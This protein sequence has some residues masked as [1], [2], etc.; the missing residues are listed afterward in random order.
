MN[1]QP[2]I[3]LLHGWATHSVQWA[4]VS[5]DLESAGYSVR[6]HDLPGYRNRRSESGVLNLQELVDDALI[7]IGDCDLWVGW[8]LGSMIALAAAAQSSSSIR[9]VMAVSGTARFCCDSE[10]EDSLNRLRLAVE[11][12][13]KKAVKRF[14]LSMLPPAVRR[15]LAKQ[16][17]EPDLGTGS[18]PAKF[19]ATLLAGLEILAQADLSEKVNKISVPVHLVSG[20]YDEII[21]ASSGRELHTLI[22]GSQFT[23]MPCGHIPFVECHKRFMETLFEFAQT[24]AAA[25]ASRKS[26]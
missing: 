10:K 20:E 11:Q 13:P 4:T 26:V 14:G 24:I 2:K 22:P 23:Q 19:T 18:D 25:P 16:L 9:G 5:E 17:A 12:N 3:A 6:L 15:K 8:S 7:K 21:P 1:S